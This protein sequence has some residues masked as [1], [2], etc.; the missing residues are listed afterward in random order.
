MTQNVL[1]I[2]GMNYFHR[3]RAGSNLGEFGTIYQFFRMLRSDIEKRNPDS[4]YIVFEGNP[5]ARK[6]MDTE[7]KANRIVDPEQEPEK[8]ASN[9]KFFDH[10]AIA[11]GILEKLPNISIVRHPY[12][13][14]DD[15]IYNVIKQLE[16]NSVTLISTDTDFIQLLQKFDY[17]SIWNPIRKKFVEAPEYNYVSWKA[18][19]GDGADN[20]FG[21][22]G[23]GD[24]RAAKL[25]SDRTLLK[26][27]LST[28]EKLDKYAMNYALIDFI[29]FDKDDW[30]YYSRS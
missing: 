19:K 8:H 15:T 17:V 3:A 12:H 9:V 16:G 27:F 14:A 25:C 10:V 1:I 7:Y 23:I 29:D 4:V 13:E 22:D 6:A 2:D 28:E 20:I 21:F 24:K 11:R 30:Q 26:E 18:L 5:I